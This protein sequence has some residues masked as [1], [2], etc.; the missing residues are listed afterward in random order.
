MIPQGLAGTHPLFWQP[1][2]QL[3]QLQPDSSVLPDAFVFPTALS[4]HE[5]TPPSWQ[6]SAA[7]QG[8]LAD[9]SPARVSC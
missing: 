7:L 2:V 4:I 5:A 6:A 3:V 9:H 8:W 1:L